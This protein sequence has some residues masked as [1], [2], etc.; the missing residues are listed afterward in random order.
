MTVD[1]IWSVPVERIKDFFLAQNDVRQVDNVRFSCGQ[2]E[3]LLTSL[4]L[5]R[6]GRFCFPQTR[7]EF[8]GPKKDTEEIHRRFILQFISAGG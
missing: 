1:E 7:V 3:I 8:D 6:V 2:C 4:P 5:R